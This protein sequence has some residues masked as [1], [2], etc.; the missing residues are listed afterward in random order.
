MLKELTPQGFT[1]SSHGFQCFS[2]ERNLNDVHLSQISDLLNL[3]FYIF[4][5][6]LTTYLFFLLPMFLFTCLVSVSLI[7]FVSSE[8]VTQR[9]SVK[10]GVLINFAN[11]QAEACNFIEKETQAQVFSCEF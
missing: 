8:A 11:F 7:S 5:N 2:V 3:S 1:Q 6:Y 9:C 10:K 4:L